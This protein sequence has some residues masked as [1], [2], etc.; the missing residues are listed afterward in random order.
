MLKFYKFYMTYPITEEFE[1]L[2]ALFLE[3][4]LYWEKGEVKRYH[5]KSVFPCK[6]YWPHLKTLFFY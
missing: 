1:T 5:Y 2:L 4:L 3:D 6:M